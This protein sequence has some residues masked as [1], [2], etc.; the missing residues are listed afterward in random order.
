[1][2][3]LPFRRTI[4]TS[5]EVIDRPYPKYNVRPR[6]VRTTLARIDKAAITAEITSIRCTADEMLCFK[7]GIQGS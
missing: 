2:S 6:F 1:M 7:Y 5:A 4:W 3:S